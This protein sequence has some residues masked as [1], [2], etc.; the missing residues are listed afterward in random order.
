MFNLFKYTTDIDSYNSHNHNHYARDEPQR[1]EYGN[2][3][4]NINASYQSF[5]NKCD[6]KKD[7]EQS[8]R[9]AEIYDKT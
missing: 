7:C 5:C 2:P 4:T 1:D 3:T 6:G 8:Y 9:N